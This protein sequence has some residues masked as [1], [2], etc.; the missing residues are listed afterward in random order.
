[1]MVKVVDVDVDGS[2]KGSIIV[3]KERGRWC[4]GY[5]MVWCALRSSKK[6]CSRP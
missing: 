6:E 5:G 1:M 4:T 3:N 2:V